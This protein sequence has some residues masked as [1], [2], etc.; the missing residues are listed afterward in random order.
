MKHVFWKHAILTILISSH[1][2]GAKEKVMNYLNLRIGAIRNSKPFTYQIIHPVWAYA[3]IKGLKWGFKNNSFLKRNFRKRR[4][5]RG[6][7][8]KMV[9][10]QS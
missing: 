1:D 9:L 7:S 5:F 4:S 6:V 8:I 10:D 2:Y 3:R